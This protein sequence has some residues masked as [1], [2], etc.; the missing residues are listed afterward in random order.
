M[1]SYNYLPSSFESTLLRNRANQ[2]YPHLT[3]V[4][5]NMGK[6]AL[7]NAELGSD[8][9][10]R[11]DG[12]TRNYGFADNSGR[13]FSTNVFG[14]IV[15]AAHGTSLGAAGTH[16][17]GESKQ[18]NPI[19]DR[20]KV[21]QQ[22]V[23]GCP[24]F[25]P[26]SLVDDFR[27]QIVVFQDIRDDD[28]D[29]EDGVCDS[30]YSI[31]THTKSCVTLYEHSPPLDDTS[32]A[33]SAIKVAKDDSASASNSKGKAKEASPRRMK[34]R[35]AN[36][37][38]PEDEVPVADLS[39]PSLE[40]PLSDDQLPTIDAV[41]VA[42][43]YAPN[44]YPDYG[45]PGFQHRIAKARQPDFRDSQN[46]I[47]APWT[48]W[49][50]LRPGT[51]IMANILI[52]VWVIPSKNKQGRD[53]LKKIYHA[54]IKSLRVLGTSDVP[55]TKPIPNLTSDPTVGIPEEADEASAALSQLM[56]PGVPVEGPSSAV[57]T[58]PSNIG[59]S[60]AGPSNTSSSDS[61]HA[62]SGVSDGT[63]SDLGSF[64]DIDMMEEDVVQPLVAETN[65]R[66]TK[67]ARR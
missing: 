55:V 37:D 13:I 43:E 58:S 63:V 65:G 62:Q 31:P 44:V 64:G 14:E 50:E 5:A 8:F 30:I 54:V 27:D 53:E 26:Q 36:A 33:H 24:S 15:G 60:S 2:L 9:V 45:G 22:I 51:L 59:A 10:K 52:V 6:S 38:V 42:A 16:H 47:V 32:P 41:R 12:R 4:L 57:F 66:K 46:R 3:S 21:K 29:D 11:I 39:P 40:L 17:W 23:I 1:S 18:T 34:K 20:T 49:D 61:G 67:K 48:F 35:K 19:T 28:I 7:T 56:L 25:A